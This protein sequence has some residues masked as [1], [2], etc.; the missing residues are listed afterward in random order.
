M[1]RCL[2]HVMLF[3]KNILI[4][5]YP[6]SDQLSHH[7]FRRTDLDAY[8]GSKIDTKVVVLQIHL[9]ADKYPDKPDRTDH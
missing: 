3:F 4:S 6:E 8:T 1:I 7:R 9:L 5:N 2:N